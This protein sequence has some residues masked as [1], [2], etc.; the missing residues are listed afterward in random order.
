MHNAYSS[1]VRFMKSSLEKFCQETDEIIQ[2]IPEC[3]IWEYCELWLIYGQYRGR[4]WYSIWMSENKVLGNIVIGMILEEG[5]LIFF[6]H[7]R[8]SE[9]RH[10]FKKKKKIMYKNGENGL[11]TNRLWFMLCVGERAWRSN[12]IVK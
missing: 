7:F 8:I 10:F 2:G 6:Y 9:Y 11:V 12:E 3:F 5:C 4:L 1:Q